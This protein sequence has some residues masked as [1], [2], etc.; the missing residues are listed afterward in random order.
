MQRPFTSHLHVIEASS[1]HTSNEPF[2]ARIGQVS[3][4]CDLEDLNRA[5]IDDANEGFGVSAVHVA[6]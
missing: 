5:S 3:A 6:N 2:A 4:A 1:S